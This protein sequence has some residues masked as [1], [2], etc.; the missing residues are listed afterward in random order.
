MRREEIFNYIA[1]DN[2]ESAIQVDNDFEAAA[3]R[4]ST[5]P[6]SGRPGAIHGTRELVVRRNYILVYSVA[7]DTVK[8]LSVR[9]AARRLPL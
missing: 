1:Q 8:I 3:R 2:P 5:F 6:N 9:H 7:Q 4:L